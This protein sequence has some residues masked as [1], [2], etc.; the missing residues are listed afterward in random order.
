L[1]CSCSGTWLSVQWGIEWV[2]QNYQIRKRPSISLFGSGGSLSPT[3][4]NTIQ[5]S[6]NAGIPFITAAGNTN[7]D[8]CNYTPSRMKSAIVAGATTY[9]LNANPNLPSQESRTTF[10]NTGSCIDVFAPGQNLKAAFRGEN[11]ATSIS[12]GTSMSAAI[13]AGV[14]AVRLGHL[15]NEGKAIPTPSVV[16]Q[17][18]VQSA[19]PN[20]IS[21]VGNGSPNL[22]LYSP[23]R[24]T[25]DENITTQIQNNQ[26]VLNVGSH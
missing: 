5:A 19:T 2:I 9:T 17:F 25:L 22:M 8:A 11:S 7:S 1:C 21:N 12:S 18:I 4:E 15:L 20:L 3:I 24:D 14:V 26:N 10:S 6:I 23:Y 16:E 13:L